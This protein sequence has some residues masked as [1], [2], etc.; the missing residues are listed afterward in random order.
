[1]MTSDERMT[2]GMKNTRSVRSSIGM[3]NGIAPD[4]LA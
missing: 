3:E 2:K 1:M 4:R